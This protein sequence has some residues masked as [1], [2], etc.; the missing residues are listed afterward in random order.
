MLQHGAMGE[1][2]KGIAVSNN[3]AQPRFEASIEREDCFVIA[4]ENT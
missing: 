4:T 3:S 2:G 1:Q